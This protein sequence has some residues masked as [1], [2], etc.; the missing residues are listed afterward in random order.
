MWNRNRNVNQ[1]PSNNPLLNYLSGGP[2][3]RHWGYN[4]CMLNK[5]FIFLTLLSDVEVLPCSIEL[6]IPK[7]AVRESKNFCESFSSLCPF[8]WL[9]YFSWMGLPG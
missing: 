2:T 7:V 4:F 6:H 8:R 5:K 1:V 3:T 9:T